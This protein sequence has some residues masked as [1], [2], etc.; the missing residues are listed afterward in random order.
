MPRVLA[1]RRVRFAPQQLCLGQPEEAPQA[2]ASPTSLCLAV[3]SGPGLFA[4]AQCHGLLS[5]RLLHGAAV[6]A[7]H[8]ITAPCVCGSCA[9]LGRPTVALPSRYSCCSMKQAGDIACDVRFCLI[10]PCCFHVPLLAHDRYRR[11]DTVARNREGLSF[12]C[13]A[14]GSFRPDLTFIRQ[15]PFRNRAS[16]PRFCQ[17]PPH[18]FSRAVVGVLG[19]FC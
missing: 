10:S 6:S 15:N 13:F 11:W 14:T 9:S 17:P 19:W 4:F 18:L 7:W 12:V 5:R 8:P 2:T 16:S 1:V 3:S